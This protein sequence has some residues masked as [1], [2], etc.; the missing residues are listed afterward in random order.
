MI[1]DYNV[2]ATGN[3]GCGRGTCTNV[4]GSFVCTVLPEGE[5]DCIGS[6]YS[7]VFVKLPFKKWLLIAYIIIL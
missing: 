5:T 7:Y 6:K 1:T 4:L 3:G 2:C